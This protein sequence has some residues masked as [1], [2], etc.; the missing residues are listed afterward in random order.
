MD[1]PHD[2]YASC[3]LTG[4]HRA[5]STGVFGGGWRVLLGM[6][7]V[8]SAMG[9]PVE[10]ASDCGLSGM[11]LLPARTHVI[12][13]DT[14][15][16]DLNRNG[17]VEPPR[18]RIRLI[19]V[20]TPEI[21]KSHKGL[22]LKFG[23]PARD[24][25]VRF[26]ASAPACLT[27]DPARPIGNYG[28]T[29]ALLNVAGRDASLELIRAGHS[30]FDT[31]F[32]FPS[33]YETYAE[34][35]GRAFTARRGIWSRAKSRRAYLKRLRRELKTPR[36]PANPLIVARILDAGQIDLKAHLQKYLRLSGTVLRTRPVGKGSV[37]LWLQGPQNRRIKVF[38]FR[39]T[40]QKLGV[41]GW[42]GGRR[43]LLEGFVKMY[44]GSP[45]LM[46]HYGRMLP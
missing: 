1:I 29:L 14:F 17:R 10:A 37:L 32:G 30:Y 8:L 9:L 2:N 33:D 31:R 43:V 3:A 18:E 15:E 6:A 20:D 19:Y 4:R 35:E 11:T 22:D 46:L 44:R 24:F 45:E 38:A 26:L 39:R 40:V 41:A 21:S 16:A 27:I 25:L 42:P 28:R 5:G 36:S 7:A 34:V 12:D 13:G 23:L